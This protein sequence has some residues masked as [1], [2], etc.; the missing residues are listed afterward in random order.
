MTGD[1]SDDAAVTVSADGHGS[2][3][4]TTDH[5]QDSRREPTDGEPSISRLD[6]LTVPSS[7]EGRRTALGFFLLAPLGVLAGVLVPDGEEVLFALAGIAAFAG[8]ITYAIDDRR[9]IDADT[10]ER[11][12][13]A[14][15]RN[16]GRLIDPA[17]RNGRPSYRPASAL[18]GADPGLVVPAERPS[19]RQANGLAMD[20]GDPVLEP[21]GLAFY[22]E[23]E[24]TSG[25]R[26]DDGLVTT[27]RTE[28]PHAVADALVDRFELVDRAV[29][30]EVTDA[31]V[32]L[33]VTNPTFGP[34]DRF[35]HPVVSFVGTSLA[36][37]LDRSVTVDRTPE[38]AGEVWR[39]TCRLEAIEP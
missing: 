6:R 21:T 5:P 37:G 12:Y 13:A 20:D 23:F 10:G 30:L 16:L 17:H 14:Y 15:A 28:L 2:I 26:P 4:G 9:L 8:V 35:D 19:E 31:R 3:L 34:L 25:D 32:E 29:V 1:E 11:V 39:L 18:D 24:R 7:L 33:L 38:A 27:A 36:S 22:R